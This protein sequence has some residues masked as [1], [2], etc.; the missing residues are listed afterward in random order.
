MCGICGYVGPGRETIL[1]TMAATLAH[2]GP[3]GAGRFVVEGVGLAHRRLAVIDLEGGAQPMT[4][5]AGNVLV[6][7]GEI[8]NFREL[9]RELEA[10]GQRFATRSDSEVLLAAYRQWGRECL[11]RLRG[12]FAFALWDAERRELFVARDRVGIKPLYY[13]AVGG[14]FYFASEAK[15]LLEIP[16]FRRRLNRTALPLYLTFRYTPGEQTL[17]DGIRKLLPGHALTVAAD[18]SLAVSQYWSLHFA[19]DEGPSAAQWQERFWGTFE[20]AVRLRMISDVPLGAYLSGGL[21]SSLLVAAMSGLSS[22]PVDAFSVGFR[23]RRFNEL[24]HAAEVARRFGCRHHVL[25]AEDE[26][27]ALL[28]PVIYHLDEPL[29]DLAA[30]PT[31][32]MARQTKPHVSVVLSGEGADEL[33]AGYPKYRAVLA[34]RRLSPWLPG[35][36]TTA[37]S[38]FELPIA[39]SR[40]CGSLARTDA[41][42]AYLQLTAV[43]TAEEQTALLTAPGRDAAEVSAAVVRPHFAAGYDGLSAM[44]SLDCQT[45]LPDDLL[46]KNDKMTMAHGVEARV[47]Y[48]DHRL[49]ELCARIPS[50]FKLNW[51]Q[52]KLLL[53]RAMVGRLPASIRRRRKA[54]FTVPLAQWMQGPFG[55]PVR[56]VFNPE[57][58]AAQGLFR[59]AYLDQLLRRPLNDPYYRRQFWTVAALGLWMRR[60]Q[61]TVE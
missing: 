34:G 23:D 4:D 44:L 41:V 33:L 31:Y 7:N 47:P 61:V 25:H 6:F 18:G 59:S 46:L 50:R 29:G 11:S 2:R 40:M 8:Y 16:G 20:E 21:D 32:L 12:M 39:W 24:P 58:T 26:A 56:A 3:D 45:W 19:P 15:A 1:E 55:A 27:A 30:I 17:F 9:R 28:D 52:E 10:F 60:F 51:H 53:R 14:V 38:R 36:L 42:A 54:G 49:V 43:F 22:S 13:A 57:F 35:A 37:A 48:L 5:A